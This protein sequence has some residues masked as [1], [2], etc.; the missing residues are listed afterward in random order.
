LL[1][2]SNFNKVLLEIPPTLAFANQPPGGG[3]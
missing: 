1:V 3:R 2:L